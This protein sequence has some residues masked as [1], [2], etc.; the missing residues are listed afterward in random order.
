MV[1]TVQ[2]GPIDTL[3]GWFGYSPTIQL[4]QAQ[5]EAAAAKVAAKAAAEDAATSKTAASWASALAVL[6]GGLSVFYIRK[7]K[8][9]T[10]PP[11]V[12][13]PEA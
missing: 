1:G 6:F 3:F 7:D 2:A 11:T 12:K 5:K 9:G 13:T 8:K 10:V 4:E